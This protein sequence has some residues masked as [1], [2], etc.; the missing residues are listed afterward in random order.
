MTLEHHQPAASEALMIPLCYRLAFLPKPCLYTIAAPQV[1][2]AYPVEAIDIA[3]EISIC[4]LAYAQ[5]GIL[6]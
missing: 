4:M 3:I 2:D 1:V 6:R 5:T